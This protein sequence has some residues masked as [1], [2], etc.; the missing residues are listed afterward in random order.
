MCVKPLRTFLGKSAV[1]DMT[2]MSGACDKSVFDGNAVLLEI[3]EEY[4]RY[5][6]MYIG[7][8]MIYSIVTNDFNYK[9][10]SNVGNNLT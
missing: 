2:K 10:I 4:G 5:R 3:S 1:C 8:D 9:I 6:F 7:E